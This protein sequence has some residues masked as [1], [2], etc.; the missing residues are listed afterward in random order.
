MRVPHS[1]LSSRSGCAGRLA[2]HEVMATRDGANWRPSS[3]EKPWGRC[4]MRA[5]CAGRKGVAPVELPSRA[6]SCSSRAARMALAS[7]CCGETTL[8]TAWRCVQPFQHLARI[9]RMCI[10]YRRGIDSRNLSVG[11]GCCP[12]G[13]PGVVLSFCMRRERRMLPVVR[14]GEHNTAVDP[15]QGL[16]A[17]GVP[18]SEDVIPSVTTGVQMAV[19]WISD[20]NRNVCTQLESD[21]S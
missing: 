8:R 15:T 1:E 9:S 17:C 7:W 21:P 18:V 4:V 6:A 10:W 13:A 5:F 19:S 3:T 14:A 12:S 2:A 16:S 20:S 11:G